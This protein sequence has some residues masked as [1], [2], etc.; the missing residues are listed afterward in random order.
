V[1]REVFGRKIPKK[2]KI[3]LA[4]RQVMGR[5]EEKTTGGGVRHIKRGTGE[6]FGK[7]KTVV[8]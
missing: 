7:K 4:K 2:E 6:K 3:I 8:Q 1:G 5:R